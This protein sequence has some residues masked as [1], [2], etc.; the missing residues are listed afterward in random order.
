MPDDTPTAG[1]ESPT[2]P[3][4]PTLAELR[5]R[6]SELD[7]PGRSK[8]DAD[9]LTSAIA[10]AEDPAVTATRPT[11]DHV[12]GRPPAAELAEQRAARREETMRT[13]GAPP[14][15]PDANEED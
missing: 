11:P 4:P 2:P 7:V 5:A 10:A 3:T 9:Q 8:M 15:N 6:A 1:A 14:E 13:I 12:I